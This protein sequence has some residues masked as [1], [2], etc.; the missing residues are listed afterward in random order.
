M[1]R[2]VFCLLLVLCLLGAQPVV[3][4]EAS[5]AA[6]PEA[7]PSAVPRGTQA[8]DGRLGGSRERIEQRYGPPEQDAEDADETFA[9]YT[10]LGDE[11]ITVSFVA[12]Q[13][14]QISVLPARTDDPATAS[15]S[16]WTQDQVFTVAA[17]W[18]PADAVFVPQATY[19]NLQGNLVVPCHSAALAQVTT[20]MIYRDVVRFGVPGDCQAVFFPA[21][22]GL[23]AG[24][25]VE[26]GD[27]V[28]LPV[29]DLKGPLAAEEQTYLTAVVT[30]LDQA[31]AS[32]RAFVAETVNP[33][34][35]RDPRVMS[36]AT[37]TWS[38]LARHAQ[39]MSAPPRL[40]VVHTVVQAAMDLLDQAAVDIAAAGEGV[41]DAALRWQREARESDVWR[42]QLRAQITSLLTRKA[43]A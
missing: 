23:I 26:L 25:D 17:A 42:A 37:A 40:E 11:T 34:S 32:V 24:M 33:T 27:G 30:L 12:G 3:A 14:V 38:A 4:Q 7:S 9:R 16:G 2:L 29:P 21:A 1:R 41:E 10:V 31:D 8:L 19:T 39:G 13:V 22:N 35:Q 15:P 18:L 28:V 36:D 20:T 43:D 5:P 6:G